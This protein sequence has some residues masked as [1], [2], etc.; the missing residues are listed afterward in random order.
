MALQDNLPQDWASYT[1]A[2]KIEHF[3]DAGV[4]PAQLAAA[5]VPASDIDYMQ[6]NGYN[7]NPNP[8]SGVTVPTPEAPPSSI[9]YPGA[10]LP[11]N[12][13]TYSPQQKIEY[14]NANG[15]T[16]DQ[17]RKYGATDTDFNWMAAN[18][19]KGPG[20]S[21]FQA[22]AKPATPSPVEVPGTTIG[23]PNIP[24][25]AQPPAQTQPAFHTPVL[26][27]LYAA[28][29]QRMF[30]PAPTFNFASGQNTAPA[31][32][33]QPAPTVQGPLTQVA[34]PPGSTPPGSSFTIPIPNNLAQPGYVSPGAQAGLTKPWEKPGFVEEPGGGIG[35]QGPLPTS[36]GGATLPADW[37]N[38]S[39]QQKIQF[40][41]QNG[42]NS[43]QLLQSGA[44]P[45][46]DLDWM[47]QNGYR[48]N[49]RGP[50]ST[51]ET[52]PSA[53][54]SSRDY[55]IRS[56]GT[57]GPS[58][59]NGQPYTPTGGAMESL[60]A[61]ASSAGPMPLYGHTGLLAPVKPAAPEPMKVLPTNGYTGLLAPIKGALTQAIQG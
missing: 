43:H 51:M 32:A 16:P 12:W 5:G 15:T 11:S 21:A 17:M 46:S 56:D 33:Q 30:S 44:V 58:I 18:G 23:N 40:F 7:P 47:Y 39:A 1:A 41:N 24:G 2:Q 9:T 54:A 4:T 14:F 42:I 35:Q 27:A 25:I 19:W 34:Q 3:N 57:Y 8:G 50:G 61:S 48:P 10:G 37:A 26:N 38:Y 53:N 59:V 52:D 20:S 28:Q 22:P 13:G 36:V 6:R 29:Q 31:P 49:D 55:I 45:Q 60:P